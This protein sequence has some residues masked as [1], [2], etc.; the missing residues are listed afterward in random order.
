MFDS[1]R[2]HQKVLQFF[3]L[4]LIVPAFVFFGVSGYEKFLTGGDEAVAEVGKQKI[5]KQDFERA[6]GQQIQQMK[7]VLGDQFDPSMLDTAQARKEVLDNLIA[8]R[9]LMS[10]AVDKR[11][12]V[13]DARL[14]QA[15]EQ[16]VPG[17]KNP[18]GTFNKELYRSMLIQQ[19]LTEAGFEAQ[20][21][22]DLAMQTSPEAIVRSAMTPKAVIDRLVSIQEEQRE[23]ADLLL[24]PSDFVAQ[25]KPT[26]EQLK[27]YYDD[28][29]KS[30]EI[31]E[32]AKV[33]YLVLSSEALSASIIV[34]PEDIKAYYDNNKVKYSVP[35]QRQAS[36]ILVSSS[37]DK[38]AAKT[39]AESLLKELKAGADFAILAKANS[40]DPG[41]GSKGGD[42]GFFSRD[43]MVKPFSDA[44]YLLKE[45]QMSDIVESEFGFHIIKLTAVKG[46]GEKKFEEVKAEIEADYKKQKA[47]EAFAKSTDEFNTLVYEQ[48]D[49]LKP[50][51]DKLK[52][53][54][55]T[56]EGVTRS[57]V[58]PAPGAKPSLLNS[59]KLLKALFSDDA[60][61]KKRNVESVEV[62]PGTLVSARIVEHKPAK[63]KTF[64]TVENEVRGAV[65]AAEAK[66]LTVA[67]GEAKVKALKEKADAAGFSAPRLVARPNPAGL[68]QA[69]LDAVYKASATKL[70]SFIGVDLGPAGYA[71]YQVSKVVSVDTKRVEEMRS[72][73]LPQLNQLTGQ[74]DLADLMESVKARTNIK[75]F[76]EKTSTQT[77]K[78]GGSSPAPAKAPT[79]ASK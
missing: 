6:R 22:K 40:D 53:T 24:K 79:P 25:V 51:A 69:A 56:A 7:Q 16:S 46:G 11:V 37:K 42:L 78:D 50:A 61:V 63:S 41:S 66:K 13:S 20:A 30:F 34:K 38:A 39:K 19:G 14:V 60:I 72:A 29:L 52:L 26:P 10:D 32:S 9:A 54:I 3:L 23:V 33:E 67:A 2:N 17:L 74:Q 45:G 47:Q 15:L 57:G 48:S 64:E 1:I 59:P 70:P 43:M 77:D 58:L 49:S 8:Q 35:E 18:D 5:T 36:H 4:V 12:I 68:N 27:K 28:N 31:A 55:L 65:L 44:A 73:A 21:R 75:R 62:S 76:D 71:V